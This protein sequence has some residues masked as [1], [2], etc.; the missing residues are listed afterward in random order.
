MKFRNPA[1]IHT[2]LAAYSHQAE[3]DARAKWL[4]LSGQ[5]GMDSKGSIPDGTIAQLETALDNI[6]LNLAAAGMDVQDLAKLTFYFVGTHDATQRRAAIE[7]KLGKHQPCMTVL[8][9]AGLASPS[10]KVEIDAWAC[11]E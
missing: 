1:N 9:V 4:I 5:V 10:L 2:P 3:V 11:K 8:Y 6:L 7:K